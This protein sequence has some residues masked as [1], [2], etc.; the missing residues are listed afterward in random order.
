M[1]AAVPEFS[2]RGGSRSPS[3]AALCAVLVLALLISTSRQAASG[4]ASPGTRSP[5]PAALIPIS[6]M[7]PA[8]FT[9]RAMKNGIDGPGALAASSTPG[10]GSA[11]VIAVS[12]AEPFGLAA[13]RAPES[14]IWTHWR[15]VRDG[16]A[17][18]AAAIEHCRA[19]ADA[20]TPAGRNFLDIVNAVAQRPIGQRLQA[21]NE[22]INTAVRYAS[23][24]DR[25]GTIDHWS[26]ALET[27]AAGEGDCEDYAIAKYA[28][29]QAAGFPEDGLRILLV[30]DRAVGLDHA[31]L[32]A[33]AGDRW[34][35][36]DNRWDTVLDESGA[37]R[38]EPLFGLSGD[39]VGLF[40]TPY[41]RQMTQTRGP[42]AV[43]A[44]SADQVLSRK[45]R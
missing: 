40:A 18:E 9:L 3:T 17:S 8:F 41:V 6:P 29:L 36:L 16:M 15:A 28:V 2:W 43:S 13:F 22:A 42:G 26:T 33:R 27:L 30:R 35:F 23:D 1:I 19:A 31:M 20:C 21:V 44:G 11:A 37:A 32:A 39:Q 25:H 4:S 10:R 45:Q 14:T 34:H 12:A 5:S 24:L 38:F 7:R